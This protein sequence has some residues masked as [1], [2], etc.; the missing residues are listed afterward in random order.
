MTT[1]KVSHNLPPPHTSHKRSRSPS[2]NLHDADEY[3]PTPCPRFRKKPKTKF[4]GSGTEADPID[5]TGD[6]DSDSS[7]NEQPAPPATAANPVD[8]TTAA[9]P[10]TPTVEERWLRRN[11]P[12][13]RP[14]TMAGQRPTCSAAYR[15]AE[16][17]IMTTRTI[18]SVTWTSFESRSQGHTGGRTLAVPRY[19]LGSA[20]PVSTGRLFAY[21]R[22]GGW[23]ILGGEGDPKYGAMSFKPGHSLV[24]GFPEYTRIIPRVARTQLAQFTTHLRTWLFSGEGSARR[25][26]PGYLIYAHQDATLGKRRGDWGRE[27]AGG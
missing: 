24:W 1:P 8:L 14:S 20:R 23:S 21:W 4:A 16:A 12:R 15:W 2:T 6:D 25:A 18:M 13:N 3:N 9:P 17:A 26:D 19:G 10:A 22:R 7:S 11:F 27:R 5:L